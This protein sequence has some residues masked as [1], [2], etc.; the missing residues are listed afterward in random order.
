MTQAERED[1]LAEALS[2]GIEP[3]CQVPATHVRPILAALAQHNLTVARTDAE[4]VTRLRAEFLRLLTEDGPTHDRRRKDYNQAI[5]NA[6]HG[7]AIW[8]S[9][10]LE[11]V[12]SKFDKAARAL[13]AALGKEAAK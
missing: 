2:V 10:D 9:T 4:T 1:A 13:T 6:E 12:M 8:T 7:W 11:M 5:F 3:G